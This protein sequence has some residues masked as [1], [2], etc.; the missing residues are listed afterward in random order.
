MNNKDIII[1]I[2]LIILLIYIFITNRICNSKLLNYYIYDSK[3]KG[4]TILLIAGTHGNEPAGT[5]ALNELIKKLNNKEIILK[6]GKLIIIPSLN[7]CALKLG[8]R[9][10]IPGGDY[11]RKYPDN[12]NYNKELYKS[13]Y[14]VLN[15]VIE[16]SQNSDF[17]I[18]FHEG[19]GYNIINNKSMGSSITPTD[20]NE[21]YIISK[22]FQNNINSTIKDNN[23]KFTIL[24][25]KKY[26]N[27]KN[28]YYNTNI[29]IKG[30]FRYFNNIYNKN[31]ILIET[32]GQDNIQP[33]NIR[34][35]QINLFINLLLKYYNLI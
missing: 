21:S 13:L 32:T 23:K 15:K 30:S 16:L 8:V 12:I 10:I 2:L 31:Y 34:I 19:W 6:S 9:F 20:T 26:S 11:N 14:P 3:N 27:I 1:I 18:D 24:F 22:L 7:F 35:N 29:D 25:N 5:Y 17:I 4:K 33:L 28:T